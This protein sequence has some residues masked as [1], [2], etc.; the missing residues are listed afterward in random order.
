MLPVGPPMPVSAKDRGEFKSSPCP[1][2]LGVVQVA[3]L[4]N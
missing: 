4:A 2:R 3:N 1:S